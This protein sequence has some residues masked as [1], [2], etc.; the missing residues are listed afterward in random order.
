[1]LDFACN[2]NDAAAAMTG[3]ATAI[4]AASNGWPI[5][6]NEQQREMDIPGGSDNALTKH[7]AS[8]A[9]EE[10]PE[11]APSTHMKL[12]SSSDVARPP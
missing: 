6:S 7:Q 9:T 3:A 8:D 5:T 12:A 11:A 2:L 1:M 10:W 4:S